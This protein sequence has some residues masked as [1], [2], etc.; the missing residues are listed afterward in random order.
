MLCHWA[1]PPVQ[2]P[3]H[4]YIF[5]IFHNPKFDHLNITKWFACASVLMRVCSHVVEWFIPYMY[6][7]IPPVHKLTHNYIFNIFHNL[8]FVSIISELS[9]KYHR[10][11]Y[12]A[13]C[14]NAGLFTCSWMIYTLHVVNDHTRLQRLYW[15]WASIGGTQSWTGDL[16]IC[17]QMLYH[18]A[19][20]PHKFWLHGITCSLSINNSGFNEV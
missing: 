12:M 6:W 20:P 19:I 13:K 14:F 11:T 1:I 4:N 16:L 2:I 8:T 3:A 5:N 7:A 15:L 9:I 18:W 10:M 17:S